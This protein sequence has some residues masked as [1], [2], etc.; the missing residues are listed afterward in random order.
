MEELNINPL[1]ATLSGWLKVEFIDVDL[2]A[3]TILT[4]DGILP[5]LRNGSSFSAIHS[6]SISQSCES[7]PGNAYLHNITILLPCRAM[8][9]DIT[10]NSMT[11]RRFILR[12]TD[13]NHQRFIAGCKEDPL[14]FSFSNADNGNPADGAAYTIT[15]SG[16]SR[17]PLLP[18]RY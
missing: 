4:A 16:L 17:L 3:D 9:H 2:V 8:H 7:Q 15:F 13:N 12:L 10:F 6:R 11:H 14:H 1:D 18:D 5:R